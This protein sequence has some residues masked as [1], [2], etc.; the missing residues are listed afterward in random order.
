MSASDGY[1]KLFG[2]INSDAECVGQPAFLKCSRAF[3]SYLPEGFTTKAKCQL[4]LEGRAISE[5]LAS[6][7]VASAAIAS[8][9]SKLN[10]RRRSTPSRASTG[11]K[12]S[13]LRYR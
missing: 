3:E 9:C 1:G 12:E 13:I 7:A 11:E 2:A 5:M 10:R 4:S 6:G 8:F